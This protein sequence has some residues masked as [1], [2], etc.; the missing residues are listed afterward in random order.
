[1]I[2]L[3]LFSR[4]FDGLVHWTILLLIE[5]VAP[6]RNDFQHIVVPPRYEI[7]RVRTVDRYFPLQK[8]SRTFP[9]VFQLA[10]AITCASESPA[11]CALIT[12]HESYFLFVLSV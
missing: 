3:K 10:P 11:F 8:G 2:E 7:F 1:M 12:F 9:F 5:L 6:E 4:P